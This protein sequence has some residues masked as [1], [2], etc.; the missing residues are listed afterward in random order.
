MVSRRRTLRLAAGTLAAVA[1]CTAGDPG[2][3]STTAT[4]TTTTTT[5]T[6][7]TTERTDTTTETDEPTGLPE[8]Q[9]AWHRSAAEA[10]VLGLDADDGTLYAAVGDGRDAPTVEA[11]DP[12]SGR[13]RWRT[14]LD[15]S[16][17]YGSSPERDRNNWGV[18]VDGARIYAVTGRVDP[19]DGWTTVHA[20]DA[21]S[22]ERSW[23]VRRDRRFEVV[24]VGDGSLFALAHEFEPEV[25]PEREAPP[26]PAALLALDAADGSVRWTRE[27][28]RARGGR[29]HRGSVHVV[30]GP[31]LVAFGFDGTEHW[32]FV[33]DAE[34]RFFAP[35][36]DRLY[37]VADGDDRATVHGLSTDGTGAWNRTVPADGWSTDGRRLYGADRTGVYALDP[38]GTTA[39]RDDRSA[40]DLVARPAGETLYARTGGDAVTAYAAADGAHRWTFQP[41]AKYAWPE[42]A[43]ADTAV[44]AGMTGTESAPSNDSLFAVDANSGDARASFTVR[45]A[46][47]VESGD[48]RVFVGTDR[49]GVYAF[50]A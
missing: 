45:T 21:A 1:G 40:I 44:C 29:V 20:L 43:T 3:P 37:F 42:T 11:F 23:T 26:Q 34:A 24:G 17:V 15:G 32:R 31:E 30:A 5:T 7:T 28:D 19:D 13:H 41:D 35:A 47:S 38:D 2:G 46:F 48:G 8:W 10:Y 18:T 14:P 9:P 27:F 49:A 4:T 25:G 33:A 36:G 22:G 50:D 39:W 6:R 16:A 12:A